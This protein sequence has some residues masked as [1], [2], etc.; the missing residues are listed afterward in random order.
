MLVTW[1]RL[2]AQTL[3]EI[4]TVKELKIG[5]ESQVFVKRG[6]SEDEEAKFIFK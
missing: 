5:Q 2:K 1:N 3:V 6:E 4:R